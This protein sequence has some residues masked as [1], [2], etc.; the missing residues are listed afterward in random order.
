MSAESLEFDDPKNLQEMRQIAHEW[1]QNRPTIVHTS[2]SLAELLD[3]EIK[4]LRE[5]IS[6]GKSLED[7]SLEVGDV[8]FSVL[9][10]DDG[11]MPKSDQ[12]YSAITT[13]CEICGFD[14]IHLF[15][16]VHYKNRVNYPVTFFNE[17]SPF[18]KPGDAITCL[19]VLRNTFGNPET[20]DMIWAD[21]DTVIQG[22]PFFDGWVAIGKFRG[23]IKNT[24]K[25][26]AKKEGR[27]SETSEGVGKLIAR[28]QWSMVPLDVPNNQYNWGHW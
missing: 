28:G 5:A 23:F 6:K 21:S 12:V 26:V 8:F 24:L 19:R 22:G 7:I 9:A 15:K 17:M 14:L 10:M 27:G 11:K 13:Y 16:N 4:E 3:S 1:I 20:L 2:Q 25:Q 18:I